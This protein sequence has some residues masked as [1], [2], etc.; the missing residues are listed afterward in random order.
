MAA[1]YKR[2]LTD[3]VLIP[4]VGQRRGR[5]N[6]NTAT[7]LRV[8]GIP[9]AIAM[10]GFRYMGNYLKS[11]GRLVSTGLTT[12][13][14]VVVSISSQ[15]AGLT[16]GQFFNW[17]AVFA[18]SNPGDAT[19]S[20][21]LVPYFRCFSRS[22]NVVT[23]G[24]GGENQNVTPATVTYSMAANAF[25]GVDCLV[26]EQ[27]EIFS[28][29]TTTI[30]ASTAT[31]ITL[32]DATGIGPLD[33]FLPAP[34]GFSE[35][36]Y[37]GTA[38]W[39]GPTG[40]WRNI[41]DTGSVVKARMVTVAEVPA[42]GALSNQ[43]IRFGGHISPLATGISGRYN[44]VSSTASLGSFGE[45]FA[46]DGGGH[47]IWQATQTKEATANCTCLAVADLT[48]SKE[49]AAWMTTIGTLAAT[50]T[51]RTFLVYGWPEL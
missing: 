34:P 2:F 36:H 14:H 9:D 26:I 3:A 51:S 45:T 16:S 17:Y 49:Q 22:G 47:D 39:E 23:L 28:G 43:K 11:R 30:T 37:L 5:I 6:Y 7:T 15:L 41:A 40:D 20:Y 48:F 42:T 21:R 1:V 18:C 10:G 24:H 29:R 4:T 13:A 27:G 38:F 12:T 46:H 25:A 35:Y 8:D 33:F 50:V 31:T 32:A 19:V 44:A